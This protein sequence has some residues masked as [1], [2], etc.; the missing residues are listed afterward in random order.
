VRR[1]GTLLHQV[2][3]RASIDLLGNISKDAA[4][5]LNCLLLIPYL[6]SSIV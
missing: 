3:D 4:Q 1:I 5:C 6:L 2:N